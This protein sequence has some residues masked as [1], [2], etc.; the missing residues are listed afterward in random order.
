VTEYA[1]EDMLKTK[2]TRRYGADENRSVLEK[3]RTEP[4]KNRGAEK[5]IYVLFLLI[6]FLMLA[7]CF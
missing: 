1:E 7:P 6:F 4:V 3:N 2:E 5:S